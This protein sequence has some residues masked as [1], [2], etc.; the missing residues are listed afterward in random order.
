MKTIPNIE[1]TA[2]NRISLS[3]DRMKASL[4]SLHPNLWSQI[5]HSQNENFPLRATASFSIGSI[6]EIAEYPLEKFIE[7]SID[8]FLTDDLLTVNADLSYGDG[9]VLD[10]MS[11]ITIAIEATESVFMDNISLSANSIVQFIDNQ[12]DRI[13][14]LLTELNQK[15]LK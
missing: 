8:Y 1:L 2:W 3:L 13:S 12:S 7:I 14:Q 10:S 15:N 9:V 11:E 6:P 5:H 4:Q